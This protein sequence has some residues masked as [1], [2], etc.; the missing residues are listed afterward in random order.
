[1]SQQYASAINLLS[2]SIL[3]RCL[4]KI[5]VKFEYLFSLYITT[6]DYCIGN[7]QLFTV[8]MLK[9]ILLYRTVSEARYEMTIDELQ[10]FLRHITG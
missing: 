1:M 7:R 8:R 9:M 4:A 5:V 2:R 3:V 10:V 6:V